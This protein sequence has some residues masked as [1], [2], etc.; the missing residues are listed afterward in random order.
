LDED[1][2]TVRYEGADGYY[3]SHTL[4]QVKNNNVLIALYM[5]DVPIPQLHGFPAR[6]LNPG[7]HG[8]KQPAWITSIKVLDEAIEDYREVRG[9]DCS[10]PM[11]VDSTIFFPKKKAKVKINQPLRLGGAAF[12]GTRITKV[13]VTTDQGKTWREAEIIK[14]MDADHAPKTEH[15]EKFLDL[16]K[17]ADPGITEVE[18]SKPKRRALLISFINSKKN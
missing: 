13:E 3:A 17:D 2:G 10:P 11:A 6:I 18:R 8:V 7:F 1:A 5:N 9:W 15:Y 12:G 16:W 4:D 14:K